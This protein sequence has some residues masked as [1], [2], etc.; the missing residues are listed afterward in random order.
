MQ[1][2]MEEV[3][4]L[5][6]YEH[7]YGY[8]DEARFLKGRIK[9]LRQRWLELQAC[10]LNLY[11]CSCLSRGELEHCLPEDFES[12]QDVKLALQYAEAR[13]KKEKFDN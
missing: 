12:I 7:D 11:S 8:P 3:M 5:G 10:G 1:Y 4:N 9:E 2:C 13:L 6:V